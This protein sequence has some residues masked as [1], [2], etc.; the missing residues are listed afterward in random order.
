[1]GKEP[2]MLR[3]RRWLSVC[4]TVVA[5]GMLFAS[6][7][8]FAQD[9]PADPGDEPTPDPVK[10]V[11]GTP[12]LPPEG[13]ENQE[14]TGGVRLLQWGERI[15]MHV[16][17]RHLEPGATYDVVASR[18]V[19]PEVGDP[20]VEVETI[21]TI[22]TRDGVPPPP[23]CFRACLKPPVEES[24]GDGGWLRDWWH[25]G[26]RDPSPW[27]TRTC[28]GTA[29]LYVD[30]EGTS[31]SFCVYV[32]G[33]ESA[34]AHL[35]IL[36]AEGNEV[37]VLP[38]GETLKGAVDVTAEQ[39]AALATGETVLV[40]TTAGD[41]TA[42][43]PIAVETLEGTVKA[44]F[45]FL[46]EWRA[47]IAARLAGTGALCLDTKREDAMPFGVTDINALV[48]VTITVKLGDTAVLA[49]TIDEV[50]EIIPWHHRTH[51]PP[52]PP[53]D[54]ADPGTD[55]AGGDVA[56]GAGA[57]LQDEA[58]ALALAESAVYFDVGEVHD[59][60]FLRGDANDDGQID[61]VDPVFLLIHLFRG[62]AS[63]YCVDA[64]DAD[65]DGAVNLSDPILVLQVLFQGRSDMPA[66]YPERGFDQTADTLFC[67]SDA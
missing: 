38:V 11:G 54:P 66:P 27:P 28:S 63:S 30:R 21:G 44:C 25:D 2:P 22:T 8:A 53:E 47:K 55:P 51:E 26:N 67:G 17:V 33:L 49:G 12:L 5:L 24:A 15:A 46:E 34:V 3:E 40:V 62:G 59:A 18:T 9:D 4:S 64:A 32:R 43:P 45:S 52:P 50:K 36:D 58:D 42:D 14:A 19:T 29:L 39:L 65:D 48:G 60:S 20:T 31:L 35:Q 1:M 37:L 41:E 16:K 6:G 13:A 7:V 23:R 61:I 56:D 57:S 10:L